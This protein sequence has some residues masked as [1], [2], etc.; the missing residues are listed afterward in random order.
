MGEEERERE[1]ETEREREREEK[2]ERE[3]ALVPRTC[4]LLGKGRELHIY[5][6]EKWYTLFYKR[7]L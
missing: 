6:V 3:R 2:R 5:L 1:T 4:S 7:G